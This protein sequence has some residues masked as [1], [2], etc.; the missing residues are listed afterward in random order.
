MEPYTLLL[1]Q[2]GLGITAA[3][4]FW[5]WREERKEHKETRTK[6]EALMEARR[7]DAKDTVDKV[8]APLQGISQG[9]QMLS[10][11]IEIT[12]QQGQK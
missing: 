12:K 10:D 3:I 4:F 6:N 8:V 11:K 2:G 7:I 5:L 9:I 1:T